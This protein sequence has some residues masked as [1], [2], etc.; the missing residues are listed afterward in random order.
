MYVYMYVNKLNY[1]CKSKFNLKTL[2]DT[3][4]RSALLLSVRGA[5]TAFHFARSGGTGRGSS[6]R[7]EQDH[8]GSC[9]AA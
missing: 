7:T 3:L 4:S 8:S 9:H 6:G 5:L 1:K 2:K